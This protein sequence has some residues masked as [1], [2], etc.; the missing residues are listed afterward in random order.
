MKGYLV[1]LMLSLVC[2]SACSVS[3][4]QKNA[5]VDA[6]KFRAAADYSR[7]TRGLSVLVMKGGKVVFE[8]YQNGHSAETPWMLAS[9]TK[10]FSGVMLAAAIEDKLIDGFDEKVSA[11]IT[12]WRTDP[13]RSKITI[14]QLLSL[15]SGIEVGPNGRPPS[16][17]EAVKFSTRFEPGEKFEYGP[18]PFQVFGEVMRRK[19]AKRNETVEGYMKRR[20]FDPIGLKP[21]RWNKQENQPNLPSGAFL[22]TREWAKFGTFL[23]NGGKVDGKQIISKKLLD[24]LTKGSKANPNYGLTFWLN[25]SHTG[26]ASIA[27]GRGGRLRERLGGEE[28]G[29]N[30]ISKNGI[31][32]SIPNDLFMAAGAANQ[33]LYIIPSLDMV[34]VRQGRMT[35]FE[36]KKF[37][38]LLLSAIKK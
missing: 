4:Q 36:D 7:D 14:R 6:G 19:L 35:R 34:I 27:E 31:D 22:T 20:L 8:E 29:T 32:K 3:A 28:M 17:S 12:E 2:L 26:T 33:R 38:N 10:S 9:G 25:R 30:A 11:T 15:T 24:E 1:G 13:R 23:I 21:A 37:L 18:V 16:Y 5:I